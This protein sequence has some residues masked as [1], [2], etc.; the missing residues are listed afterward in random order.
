MIQRELTSFLEV[1]FDHLEDEELDKMA[2]VLFFRTQLVLSPLMG[3]QSM[4]T[5]VSTIIDAGM[6]R[7]VLERRSTAQAYRSAAL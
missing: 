7:V 3:T 5:L 6:Q 4:E 1:Q 2:R